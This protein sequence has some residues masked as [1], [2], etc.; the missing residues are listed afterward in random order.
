M[1][2]AAIKPKVLSPSEQLLRR[3]LDMS[4]QDDGREI[5]DVIVIW[6]D[7]DGVQHMASAQNEAVLA[8]QKTQ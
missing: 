4:L 6:S 1:T 8:E 5:S 2:I 7:N 3:L